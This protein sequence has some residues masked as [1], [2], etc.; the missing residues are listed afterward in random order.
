MS[1]VAILAQNPYHIFYDPNDGLPS[2]ETY[3]IEVDSLNRIWVATDRGVSMYNGY[4]FTNYSSDDGLTNNTVFEIFVDINGDLIF[5]SFDGLLSTFDGQK[6]SAHPANDQLKN[7][8]RGTWIEHMIQEDSSNLILLNKPWKD[9]RHSLRYNSESD[10]LLVRDIPPAFND[11]S[12]TWYLDGRNVYGFDNFT[13]SYLDKVIEYKNRKYFVRDAMNYY[14]RRL[15]ETGI[16]S[17][18]KQSSLHVEDSSGKISMVE[19]FGSLD[20]EEIYL[21]GNML[22]ICSEDGLWTYKLNENIPFDP[23]RLFTNYFPTNVVSDLESNIW[24]STHQN[25]I[26]KIPSLNIQTYHNSRFEKPVL[27]LEVLDDIIVFS[28]FDGNAVHIINDKLEIENSLQ[29]DFPGLPNLSRVKDGIM[30]FNSTLITKQNDEIKIEKS[31]WIRPE[32][33]SSH[34]TH[35]RAFEKLNNGKTICGTSAIHVLGDRFLEYPSKMKE[36]KYSG[37]IFDIFESHDSTIF[38]GLVDGLIK[39]EDYDYENFERVLTIP[40]INSRI[41]QIQELSNHGLLLSTH[42]DGL[43][44]YDPTLG[45]TQKIGLNNGLS[46]ILINTTYLENDSTL[47]LATNNG[48]DKVTF[49]IASDTLSID[50]VFSINTSDGLLSNYIYDVTSFNSQIWVATQKGVNYFDPSEITFSSRGPSIYFERVTSQGENIIDHPTK[51]FQRDEN[52][53]AFK[54]TGISYRKPT[55]EAFYNYAL[56]KGVDSINWVATNDRNIQFTNLDH[57]DYTFIVKA[58]NKYGIW[59]ETP[60]TFSFT[61]KP[62]LIE[63]WWFR[64]LFILSIGSIIYAYYRRREHLILKEEKQKQLLGEARLKIKEAEL[65]A[66]RNQMNPHFIYNAL[67]SIQNYVFKGQRKEANFYISKFSKLMRQSLQMT[68][69]EL[70]PLSEEIQF[71]NNYLELEKMRFEEKFIYKINKDLSLDENQPI[72]P[73]LIQPLVENSIKHGFKDIDYQGEVEINFTKEDKVIKISVIDNGSG[74]TASD[75]S[76]DHHSLGTKII[77]DRLDIIN[78]KLTRSVAAIEVIPK[79]NNDKGT[80]IDIILPINMTIE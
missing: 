76:S 13:G 19:K 2:S 38:I 36:I 42:G 16:K 41:N 8:Y 71:L 46:S 44:Y 25:G 59:S 45:Y 48:L 60:A 53:I 17:K 70:V 6:I 79:A 10:T 23:Q 28:E 31:N 69:L 21:N 26:A 56:I 18:K 51:V 72:P 80:H 63:T 58:K 9:V 52:D 67:N 33:G 66:L 30:L 64:L 7:L 43:I 39:I 27:Q 78:S 61:I 3:D 22:I 20:L 35:Y 49:H 75:A 54:F 14:T 50:N 15:V 74:I 37:Q 65:N 34:R 77:R 24:I 5:S 57:G 1:S 47:W 62:S 40:E 12:V 29:D 4:E 55:T 73:L 32:D 11:E 68:K